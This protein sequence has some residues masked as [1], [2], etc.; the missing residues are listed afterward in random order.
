MDPCPFVRILVGNL[1]LKYSI[2]PKASQCFCKIK[3]NNFPTQYATVPLILQETQTHSSHDRSLAACFTLDNTHIHNY[4]LDNPVLQI[5]V[6]AGRRGAAC[7]LMNGG[8]FLGTV[9]V[10]VDLRAVETRATNIHKGWV[11]V[12]GRGSS[13]KGSS[14]AQLHL[15]VGA[16]PDPRF[17]FQFDD[18]PECSPQVFQLHRDVRQAVFSCKFG[19]KNA[20]DRSS[21]SG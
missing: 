1:A 3:L 19:F 18:E 6:Y 14:A 20:N 4:K 13:R 17:V 5:A 11:G 16:E 10:E 15:S 8:K 7:G 12:G 9:E 2:A 21:L